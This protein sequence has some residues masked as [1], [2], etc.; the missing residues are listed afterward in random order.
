MRISR[1]FLSCSLLAL[2]CASVPV[3]DQVQRAAPEGSSP[4]LVIENASPDVVRVYLDVGDHGVLLGRVGAFETAF[5]RVPPG[6]VHPASGTATINIVPVGTPVSM[7]GR[8]GVRS[9]VYQAYDLL[10]YPWRFSGTRIMMMVST[11]A[12]RS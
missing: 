10:Q 8:T 2:G 7:L 6:V 5:L 12:S 3:Q 4:R 11:R 9:D 1:T